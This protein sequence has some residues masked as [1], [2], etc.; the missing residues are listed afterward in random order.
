MARG[1]LRTGR[2]YG[3]RFSAIS[4]ISLMVCFIPQTM[5]SINSL[6]LADGRV[7]SAVKDTSAPQW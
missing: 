7:K 3:L 2:M 6:N 5:L 1:C 4:A